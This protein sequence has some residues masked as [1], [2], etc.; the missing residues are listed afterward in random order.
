MIDF[1]LQLNGVSQLLTNNELNLTWQNRAL[2]LQKDL[3]Y[4][5]QQSQISYRVDDDHDYTSAMSS[6]SE[7]FSK[8][9]NW[10][11]VKQQFLIQLLLQK[12]IFHQV[13]YHG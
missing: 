9:I 4:E 3:S 6:S 5:K 12:K 8:P 13:L 2:Q 11:A 10:V 1:N 7:T